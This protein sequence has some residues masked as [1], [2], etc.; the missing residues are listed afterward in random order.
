MTKNT[1]ESGHSQCPPSKPDLGSWFRSPWSVGRTKGACPAKGAKP[2]T[3]CPLE[4]SVDY[5]Y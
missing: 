1:S 3:A 4:L 5:L 2:A